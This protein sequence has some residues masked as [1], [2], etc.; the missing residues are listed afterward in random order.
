VIHL[1]E[2]LGQGLERDLTDMLDRYFWSPAAPQGSEDGP[3][4]LRRGGVEALHA[5]NLAEAVALLQQAIGYDGRDG[6][7][8]L[9]L[10]AA[11]GEVGRP[12]E[13]LV[14]AQDALENLGEQAPVLFAAGLLSE[15]IQQRGR[16]AEYY[17]RAIARDGALRAARQRLAAVA[18]VDGRIDEAIEQ[19]ASMTATEPGD[20]RLR[21]MLGCLYYRKGMAQ[22]AA[23]KY[24]AAIGIEP[25]NWALVDDE[26]EQLIADKH[27]TEAIERLHS[28]IDEQG[29][30]A[31]LHVRLAD[32]HSQLGNDDTAVKYYRQALEIS[33]TYL[34][35]TVKLGTH[36]LICG[37]W[38]QAA[39]LFLQAAILNDRVLANY[40]AMGVSQ[41]AAG[42]SDEADRT[43]ELAAAVEPNS[44]LLLT[45]MVC[46]HLKAASGAVL[47]GRPSKPARPQGYPG[48]DELFRK[49]IC[50]HTK[51]LRTHPGDAQAHFRYGVLLRASN[52]LGP[53][54]EQ[55]AQAV[56]LCPTYGEA[57]AR[58]GITQRQMHRPREATATFRRMMEVPEALV[59]THYKLALLHT[60]RER[61]LQMVRRMESAAAD[62]DGQIRASLALSLENMDLMDRVAAT[63]R[64]LDRLVA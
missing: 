51:A 55:F 54:A 38:E 37:R 1:L 33:P 29:P 11:H 47:S 61:F 57:I 56:K 30:F 32:L 45:E 20:G 41:E 25:E 39:E 18:V 16:A 49:A 17:R 60:D 44:T 48:H 59:E 22:R 46:L 10:A 52:R 34:E 27:I 28:L 3:A 14:C 12:Q 4:A 64:S 62:D 42:R 8:Q 50:L 13:A 2:V 26:V 21:S 53:A 58:L 5:R 7:A 9:A 15:Q 31:D 63:W 24:A 40:V 6:A 23:E 19:Y 43:F 36:H 35:A